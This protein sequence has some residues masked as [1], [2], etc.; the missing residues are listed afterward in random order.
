MPH[1]FGKQKP[2]SGTF[3][4]K[5]YKPP[6]TIKTEKPLNNLKT[7]SNRVFVEQINNFYHMIYL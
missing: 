6:S 4:I 3:T 2:F 7:W 5:T 1:V